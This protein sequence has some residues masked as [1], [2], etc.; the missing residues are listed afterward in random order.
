[1]KLSH[2]PFP[3]IFA[4]GDEAVR[5]D[6]LMF[7]QMQDSDYARQLLLDLIGE[8]L[9][10]GA[11]PSK[12]DPGKWGIRETARRAL[13]LLEA[14]LPPDGLNLF[15]AVKFILKR[16]NPDG[17]WS[18]NPSLGIPHWMVELSTERSVTWLTADIV[19]LLRQTSREDRVEYRAALDWLRGM[20]N[21]H[22]GW[23]CFSGA[24]G[25][26]LN[27]KGDPDSTAQIAF[28][29]N[30]ICGED[31]PAYLKGKALVESWLDEYA[32]DVERGYWIRLR[33]GKK[34]ELDVYHLTHLFLSH[35]GDRPRRFQSGYDL[36]DPRVKLLLEALIDI[37]SEDGGWRPFWASGSDPGYTL[38]AVKVLVLSGAIK[39]EALQSRVKELA[40]ESSQDV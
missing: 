33:D 17:G 14:G 29:M 24:I 8:Q 20:Q 13:L 37:Q 9:A 23:Y 27:A 18:E 28:L 39:Q 31:D 40:M 35:L 36:S 19:E 26:Q 22:G 5:L 21:R 15:S 1:M 32:Q 38:L 2:D 25:E 30:Q 12:I 7:F 34:E 10:H 3:L 11:F 4:R 16:Q 6:C